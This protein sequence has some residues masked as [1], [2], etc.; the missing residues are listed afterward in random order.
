[1]KRKNIWLIVCVSALLLSFLLPWI[2]LSILQSNAKNHVSQV[3]ISGQ[4]VNYGELTVAVKQTLLSREELNISIDRTVIS[5]DKEEIIVAFRREVQ[6][7]FDSGAITE[8]MYL[9]FVEE[10]SVNGYL[11]LHT[12]SS[13]AFRYYEIVSES[14]N[15]VGLFDAEQNKVLKLT[16]QF[17][18]EAYIMEA[19]MNASDT[20]DGYLEEQLRSWANYYGFTAK[21]ISSQIEDVYNRENKQP[22]RGVFSDGENSFSF[23]LSYDP[24]YDILSWGV[25]GGMREAQIEDAA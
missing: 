14:G 1:M 23:G 20:I 3:N 22:V 4:L 5:A 2:V 17:Q 19:E 18:T 9:P 24:E 21:E 13:E 12:G 8:C 10:L 6:L 16:L 7:L 11:A 25:I 15:S